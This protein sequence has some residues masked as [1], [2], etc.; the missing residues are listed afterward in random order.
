MTFDTTAFEEEA[1]PLTLGPSTITDRKGNL[2]FTDEEDPAEAFEDVEFI[3]VGSGPT[4]T[5]SISGLA[6]ADFGLGPP[7]PS[8]PIDDSNPLPYWRLAVVQGGGIVAHWVDEE[9]APAGKAIEWTLTNAAT[10]DQVYLEQFIP[11]SP[12]QRFKLPILRST[13]GSDANT[14]P[15]VSIR[16]FTRTGVSTGTE[17]FSSYDPTFS[18]PQDIYAIAGIPL[19]A[20]FARI[21]I[22]VTTDGTVAS[23]TIRFHEAWAGVPQ[24]SYETWT[25][26]D[27]SL[28]GTGAASL[29]AVNTTAAGSPTGAVVTRHA[30][31]VNGQVVIGWIEA[32][33]ASLS[34]DRT[35]GTMTFQ[36]NAL[37]GSNF[38]PIA[39]ID[40]TDTQIAWAT[41]T[42][43][44]TS[45]LLTPFSNWGVIAT[46]TG[47]TPTT[48]DVFVT[49]RVAFI[50]LATSTGGS[51]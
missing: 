19:D 47:F 36:M 3:G 22:T 43:L 4:E 20:R 12:R 42:L 33:T 34:T 14:I 5:T 21:R 2:I 39:T 28:P 46:G 6:N 32:I 45:N 25:F 35:A 1:N 37:G 40:D 7:N 30:A 17:Q 11:V 9:D 15:E 49:V 51:S 44:D 13:V 31:P 24:V 38:G 27:V 26:S 23:D 48:A 18:D 29:D 41:T 50:N 8:L 10:D 16:Y